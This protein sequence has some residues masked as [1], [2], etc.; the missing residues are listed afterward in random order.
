MRQHVQ[1]RLDGSLKAGIRCAQ[2]RETRQSQVTTEIRQ[3]VA[4]AGHRAQGTLGT[5]RIPFWEH[6]PSQPRAGPDA[7]RVGTLRCSLVHR[8][9]VASPP[10]WVLSPCHSPAGPEGTHP[11]PRSLLHHSPRWSATRHSFLHHAREFLPAA[12]CFCQPWLHSGA[13]SV[14][15]RP[16]IPC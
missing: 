7:R 6:R 1:D 9:T 10:L 11:P 15:L 13:C 12:G 14:L 3:S 5:K 2:L 8:L 16:R 4:A